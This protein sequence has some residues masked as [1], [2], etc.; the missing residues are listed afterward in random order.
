MK[1]SLPWWS[2]SQIMTK[3]VCVVQWIP[4]L[5]WENARHVE[6]EAGGGFPGKC[7]HCC[8]SDLA[9]LHS[10]LRFI[11]HLKAKWGLFL[12]CFLK[13]KPSPVFLPRHLAFPCEGDVPLMVFISRPLARHD[14]SSDKIPRQLRISASHHQPL[15]CQQVP[16]QS[17]NEGWRVSLLQA[18]QSS[19]RHFAGLEGHCAFLSLGP[20]IFLVMPCPDGVLGLSRKTRPW[21]PR[22]QSSRER[23][24]AHAGGNQCNEYCFFHRQ[25]SGSRAACGA[26]G[27]T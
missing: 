20:T 12:Q 4:D 15:P 25:S 21:R 13:K 5:L 7:H 11:I 2:H 27:S 6:W 23:E 10:S 24:Q 3:S 26:C 18:P 22:G 1:H 19:Q 17:F 8:P 16:R 9:D 14:F